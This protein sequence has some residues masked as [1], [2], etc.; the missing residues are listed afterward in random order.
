[1]R[2]PESEGEVN[3]SEGEGLPR[4]LPEAS[5]STKCITISG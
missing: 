1:M 4:E 5:Q 2:A 3:D